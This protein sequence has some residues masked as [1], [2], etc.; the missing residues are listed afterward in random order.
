MPKRY[1][2]AMKVAISLPDPW[3]RAAEALAANLCKSRSQLDAEALAACV[4]SHAGH[5]ITQGLNQV[6]AAEPSRLD[7]AWNHLQMRILSRE[8]W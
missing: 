4:G 2:G 5:H 6:Y 7:P 3:F 8:A 1:H